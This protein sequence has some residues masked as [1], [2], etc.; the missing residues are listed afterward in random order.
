MFK[1]IFLATSLMLLNA[2]AMAN[3]VILIIGDGMDDQQISIARN[4]LQGAQGQLVL[5]KMPV[6]G[7]VKVITVDEENPSKKV[8]VAD[9]A[10]SASSIA[11]GVNTSRGR[12]SSTAKTNQHPVTI[13]ELAKAKG[14]ATGVV[15]TASVTDATPAAFI[16]HS[17]HRGCEGPEQMEPGKLFYGMYKLDCDSDGRANGGKGS[18]AEQIVMGSTDVV[19][20]GGL[21]H[22]DQESDYDSEHL[23][24]KAR[25]NGFS[26]LQDAQDLANIE[27]D[28]LL[29]LFS[30]STMPVIWQGTTGAK[31]EK[32]NGDLKA[33]SCEPN[34][35]FNG[36][37]TLQAMTAKALDTLA[38][39]DDSFILMVES[40]SI[41]KQSHYRNP[42]GHIGELKQ[43]DETVQFVLDFAKSHPDTLVLVTAD[44]GHAAQIVPAGSL[45]GGQST[46]LGRVALVDTPEGS[47]MAINYATS[48]GQAEEHTGVNVPIFGNDVAE[49]LVPS[50]L[51]QT[52]I[53]SI[54]KGYLG[55]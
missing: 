51:E 31:A 2:Q 40:A 10:N 53:F 49:G 42:C 48:E 11:T 15:S 41:D 54:M 6:R 30:P 22:F 36:M 33:F 21:K 1:P 35:G 47:Q 19:L 27:G 55:L 32:I 12:I 26:V 4:Y 20:G 16:S 13:M 43:L 23:L 46:S 28:R 5:D 7:S 39:N 52:D 24:T 18:I 29:G 38:R 8:Y 45:F 14:L 37:P 3:N 50:N 44:H 9:S 34:L 17:K 25:V